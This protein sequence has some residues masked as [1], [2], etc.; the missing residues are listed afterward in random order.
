MSNRCKRTIRGTYYNA[1]IQNETS[2]RYEIHP[3]NISERSSDNIYGKSTA[4]SNLHDSKVNIFSA[5]FQTK[6]FA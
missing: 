6:D 5:L 1:A 4:I 3:H 2:F